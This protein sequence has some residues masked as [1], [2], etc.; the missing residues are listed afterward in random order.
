MNRPP[1]VNLE[2]DFWSQ[3]SLL[4]FR[5]SIAIFLTVNHENCDLEISPYIVLYLHKSSMY[6]FVILLLSD[7]DNKI[8]DVK[9][10][11]W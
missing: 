8:C 9:Y 1:E 11:A 6:I 10:E 7:F 5:D 2:T 3:F 4:A